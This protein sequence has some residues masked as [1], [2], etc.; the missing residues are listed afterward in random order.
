MD[1]FGAVSTVLQNI[2]SEESVEFLHKNY[3]IVGPFMGPYLEDLQVLRESEH[4]RLALSKIYF[5]LRMHEHAMDCLRGTTLRDDQ[6]FFYRRMLFIITDRYFPQ[7]KIDGNALGYLFSRRKYQEIMQ[8]EDFGLI[9]SLA[10]RERAFYSWVVENYEIWE[11]KSAETLF[12]KID[13]LARRGDVDALQ[14]LVDNARYP[15]S[16]EVS[17]YMYENYPFLSRLLKGNDIV[18]GSLQRRTYLDFLAKNNRTDFNFL[19]NLGRYNNKFDSRVVTV[20]SNSIMNM[21]TTNDSLYRLNTDLIL[22]TKPWNRFIG[23]ASIG[24]IHLGNEN[25]YEILQK[26]LPNEGDLKRGGSLFAL[27]LIKRMEFK[28]EDVQFFSTFLADRSL[29]GEIHYGAALGLGVVAMGSLDVE[30]LEGLIKHIQQKSELNVR[31][32]L[33]LSIGMVSAGHA[34][35]PPG[36]ERKGECGACDDADARKCT[37]DAE[38]PCR[39]E[40]PRKNPGGRSRDEMVR[41]CEAMLLEMCRESEHEREA[42]SAGIGFVLSVIGTERMLPDLVQDKNEVVKYCGALATGAAFVGTGDLEVVSQLLDLTNDGDDNVKRAAVFGIGLVCSADAGLL[43]SLLRPLAGSH[44]PSI[45]ATVALTLGFFM[46]GTGDME[47]SNVIEALLYDT[48][49]LVVQQAGLGLGFLLM[50]CNSHINRN[51]RRMVEKLNSLTTERAEDCSFKFGAVLGRSLMGAGGTNVVFSVLNAMNR[52]ET[53]RVVGAVLFFQYWF[54][55]P[56]F[57]FVSLCMKPTGFFVF[58]ENLCLVDHEIRVGTKRSAFDYECI[59]IEEPRRQR[60]FK[61][62]EAP[63]PKEVPRALEEAESYVIKSGGR[64][65]IH[66]MKTCGLSDLRFIFASK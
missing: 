35:S 59:K 11:D 22:N 45:R 44:C 52:V 46:C 56:L 65:S 40:D 64:M 25:P 28:V 13:N 2:S 5:S 42:M 12:F 48:S 57:P 34:A 23:I 18:D 6:S 30:I 63:Q 21:G 50:Q 8:V 17:Y 47:A 58:D 16:H 24:N 9:S 14:L 4:G 38:G 54:W 1:A 49:S 19:N 31:E 39:Q 53:S 61:R 32:G 33:L 10:R 7:R 29:G 62:R 43:L 20:L 51:F 27:G 15:A 36:V 26:Y 3:D 60:R 55:Y 37:K 41:L 66:E